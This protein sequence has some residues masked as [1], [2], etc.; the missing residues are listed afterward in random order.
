[1]KVKDPLIR[2]EIQ[3]LL[4]AWIRKAKVNFSG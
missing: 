4:P 1:M 3:N 2:T